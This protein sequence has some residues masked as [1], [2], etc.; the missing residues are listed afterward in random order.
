MP[1]IAVNEHDRPSGAAT[2]DGNPI[3]HPLR[4]ADRYTELPIDVEGVDR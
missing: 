3:D 1:A 4:V 2:G